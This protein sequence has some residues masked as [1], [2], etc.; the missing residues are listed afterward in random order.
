MEV[1]GG[2]LMTTD[3]CK[4]VGREGIH[5]EF[6]KERTR[7]NDTNFTTKPKSKF[8]ISIWQGINKNY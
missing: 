6:Y 5:V 7:N 3:G 1:A 2:G 4:Y 8:S